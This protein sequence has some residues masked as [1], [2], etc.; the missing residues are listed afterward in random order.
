MGTLDTGGKRRCGKES[1][2]IAQKNRQ[3]HSGEEP[4]I[5]PLTCCLYPGIYTKDVLTE[6][7]GFFLHTFIIFYIQMVHMEDMKMGMEDQKKYMSE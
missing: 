2:K 3:G 4:S 6:A 7:R 5:Y 1:N